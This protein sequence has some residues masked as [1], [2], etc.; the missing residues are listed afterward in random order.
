MRNH[1]MAA[2]HTAS[3]SGFMEFL[4]TPWVDKTIAVIAVTPN[5][6]EL[7]HRYTDANLT[8]VRGVLGIQWIILIITMVLRRPPARVTPN[9]SSWLLE[10]VATSGVI[11][12]Y[13]FAPTGT[14]R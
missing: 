6:L 14:L 4:T 11:T 2:V 7:Y 13:A 9:A 10:S 5:S 3:K 1:V 12:L 8:F